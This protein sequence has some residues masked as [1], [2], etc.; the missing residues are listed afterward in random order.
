M[1]S[2]HYPII[3]EVGMRLEEYDTGGVDRWVFRR[4]DWE[5]FKQIS[6]KEMEKFGVSQDVD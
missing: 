5:K 3:T 4:S 2:D 6:D 1:G